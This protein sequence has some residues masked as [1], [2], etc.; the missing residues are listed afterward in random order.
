MDQTTLD[1]KLTLIRA[2][3]EKHLPHCVLEED[4]TRGHQV[5]LSVTHGITN[6]CV[7]Q[8]S[9]PLLL[10]PHLNCLEL[11]WALKER[12]VAGQVRSTPQALLDHAT[13]RIGSTG[14]MARRPRNPRSGPH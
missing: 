1:S 14:A 9:L 2:Y 6:R 8:V 11:R 12:D 5:Q 10:D 13:L 7:V 4:S 3:L